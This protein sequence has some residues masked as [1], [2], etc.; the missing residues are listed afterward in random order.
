M[1]TRAYARPAPRVLIAALALLACACATASATEGQLIRRAA[2]DLQCPADAL[3]TVPLDERSV[4]VRGCARQATYVEHC[5][6]GANPYGTYRHSCTWV[7][8]SDGRELPPRDA[9][10]PPVASLDAAAR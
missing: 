6:T 10:E 4:G 2:F 7:L 8:N 9:S 5:E 1:S 3:E